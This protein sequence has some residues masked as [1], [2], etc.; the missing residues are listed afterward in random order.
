[1]ERKRLPDMTA[2][3]FETICLS[4]LSRYAEEEELKDFIIVHDKV[5]KTSDGSYQ[6]DVYAE[7][8]AFGSKIKVLCEC[9]KYKRKVDR[10]KVAVLH[11]KLES[12]G[13]HKGILISVN[14]FQSGAIAYAKAH[15]IAL[16]T[17][18]GSSRG[19][20]HFEHNTYAQSPSHFLIMSPP[21]QIKKGLFGRKGR[22][23]VKQQMIAVNVLV[24]L[25]L[26]DET[27]LVFPF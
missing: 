27:R 10:E 24:R 4:I 23:S 9:K 25:N 8:T 15:G 20:Y 19:D 5:I 12:I 16:I 3:E 14:G 11:R 26:G 22:A 1:M 6:I 13:A 17:M 7:F 18:D 2:T 21:L